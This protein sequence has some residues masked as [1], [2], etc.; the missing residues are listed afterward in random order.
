MKYIMYSHCGG[1]KAIPSKLKQEVE[2]AITGITVKAISG[3]ATKIRKQFLDSILSAGWSSKVAVSVDSN[4]TITSQKNKVGL[5]LQTGNVSRT[6]ADLLKLQTL[7]LN[8]SIESAVIVVP[9]KETALLLGSNIAQYSRLL[10]E[11]TIMKKAYTVPTLI[12]SM[13]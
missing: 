12:F 6:Y 1:D 8:N 2:N 7:Y 13:E 11:V 10:Q 4:M 5:C 9:S 3:V